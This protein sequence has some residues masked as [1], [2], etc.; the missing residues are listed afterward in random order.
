MFLTLLIVLFIVGVYY[1]IIADNR[2][3][4]YAGITILLLMM[5]YL[6]ARVG[7][8]MHQCEV[9]PVSQHMELRV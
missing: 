9:E 8:H 2:W 4:S 3:V 1:M 5:V 7:Y 6:A